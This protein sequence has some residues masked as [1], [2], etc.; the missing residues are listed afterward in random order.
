[1]PGFSTKI[2]RSHKTHTVTGLFTVCELLEFKRTR[3]TAINKC[4]HL[5]PQKHYEKTF[6]GDECWHHCHCF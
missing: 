5:P 1:M 3:E 2:I 4:P 6:S